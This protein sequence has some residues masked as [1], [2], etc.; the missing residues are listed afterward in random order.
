[1]PEFRGSW[2]VQYRQS[3][4][5][6]VIWRTWRNKE[7]KEE[8]RCRALWTKKGLDKEARH[9]FLRATGRKLYDHRAK[10]IGGG[11]QWEVN[12][13]PEKALG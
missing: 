8:S 7:S 4:R 2:G 13:E 5:N 11:G 3:V 6:Q 12:E 9:G 10:K 1:M